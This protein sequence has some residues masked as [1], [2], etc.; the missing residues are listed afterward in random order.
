M[1]QDDAAS[2]HR[3]KVASRFE[4]SFKAPSAS[5]SLGETSEGRF[6]RVLAD[7]PMATKPRSFVEFYKVVTKGHRDAHAFLDRKIDPLGF[8]ET[9]ARL[10]RR[11]RTS[12]KFLLNP[13]SRPM[14]YWD[15]YSCASFFFDCSSTAVGS[16]FTS[17]LVTE[18]SNFAL[19]SSAQ[20]GLLVCTTPPPTACI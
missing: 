14:Q 3:K 18:A 15:L 5:G 7:D 17:L 6:Q 16:I 1:L 19:A 13:S 20:R 12:N 11:L 2:R 9:A 10:R 8:S 4:G